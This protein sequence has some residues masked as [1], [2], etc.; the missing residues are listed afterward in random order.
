MP[1]RQ[2]KNVY[3]KRKQMLTELLK[4]DKKLGLSKKEQ[5]QGALSE[6]DS[7]LKTIDTLRDQEIDDNRKLDEKTSLNI[8]GSGLFKVFNDKMASRFD[9]SQTKKN[10]ML[11]FLKKCETTLR[12]E[13]YAKL[14]KDEGYE[15]IAHVFKEFSEHEKEHAKLVFKHLNWAKKTD[16]NLLESADIEKQCHSKMY[17][18]FE[19]TARKEKFKAIADFIKDLTEIEVEHEKRFIKLFKKL[20]DKSVFVSEHFVKWKCRNCGHIFESK[21]A[22]HNC[23][24]CKHSQAF[25]EMSEIT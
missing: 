8:S 21:E 25:F 15:S 17:M 2:L 12:Y 18:E 6:I 20:K 5:I 23:K 3:E 14:A 13:F 10:L 7:F 16:F 9:A 22:P 19:D 1:L 4:S 11:L 24:V